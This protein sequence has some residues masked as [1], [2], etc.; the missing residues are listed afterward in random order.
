MET[1][2]LKLVDQ[3]RL[4][5]YLG[6]QMADGYEIKRP[7]VPSRGYA[8]IE[9][10]ALSLLDSDG[11]HGSEA[12]RNSYVDLIPACTVNVRGNYRFEV[13]PNPRLLD[14]GMTQ[15]MYYLEPEEGQKIPSVKLWLRRDLDISKLDYA[16]RIYMRL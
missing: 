2:Y 14:Y 6:L 7:E 15:G 9:V 10:P 13:H 16:V 8:Y 1:S 5:N 3:T 12:N 11:K 4:R